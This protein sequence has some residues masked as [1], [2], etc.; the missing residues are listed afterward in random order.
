MKRIICIFAAIVLAVSNGCT[1]FLEEHPT[2]R[3]AVNN[4]Y[5]TQKDAEAAVSAAYQQLG[6]LY[7]RLMYNVAELPTDVMKNGL[8]MPNAFLQDLEFMR[9]NSENTF[10]RDM[11]NNNYAGIMKANAA[12]NNI[13]V[14]TMN[15]AAQE[16]LIGEA[17]FLRALYYFN[18]VRFFGDVPL[19]TRLESIN[20]AMGPRVSKDQVYA[21]IIQDLTEAGNV[22]P[23]RSQYAAADEGRAT[24]GA[25]KI[26]LGKVYL[27]KGDFADAKNKLAEVVENEADYG[28][29]LHDDYAAN[30][31]TE[32]EAGVEAVFYIE[33]KKPPMPTNG[34]MGL[35]GPKYSVPGGNIGVNGSN[36]ADIPTQELYDAF[37][38]KDKRRAKNL[39]YAFYSQIEQ[40]D[41]LSSIPLF[42]KYWIDGLT[43]SDQCDV[44]MHIIRYADAL[45]M[46]AEALNEDGQ[47]DKAHE[48][49]NRVRRRA[50]GDD[51]GNFSGLT[52]EQFRAKILDERRL[53]FPIEGHRW[54]DL[55][56]TGTFIQRMKEHSAYEA[57]VAEKNKTDIAANIKDHMTLMP[58]PQRELDLNPELTQNPGW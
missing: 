8:G 17:K 51:S 10:V 20:D 26:L 47:S 2:D 23:L 38:E 50:F 16:R 45:L 52:K 1:A 6:S 14:I 43:A 41:V 9:Y 5:S 40:A 49:L 48:V 24:R 39:R 35:A 12:V 25:A 18:L 30:W 32:T 15:A 4:F 3:L 58:I 29:A 13:P 53:E 57:S 34:E 33:Y 42:G 36:E 22:L 19:V 21:Q 28:Y 11:W 46:Y 31:N 7:N 55:V 44:N 27:T 37:D 56:R 54:F